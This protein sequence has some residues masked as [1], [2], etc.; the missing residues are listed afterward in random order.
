VLEVGVVRTVLVLN[1][2]GII[3]FLKERGRTGRGIIRERREIGRKRIL[4]CMPI[5]GLCGRRG[6]M[7]M[8]VM[9]VGG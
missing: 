9:N 5:R 8:K 4:S 6:L 2:I 1:E 7:I 3:K